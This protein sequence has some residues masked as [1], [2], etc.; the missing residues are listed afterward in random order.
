MPTISNKK[1]KFIEKNFKRC[2]I[3]E[4]SQKTGLKKHAI[5][6]LIDEFSASTVPTNQQNSKELFNNEAFWEV[7]GI[8]AIVLFLLTCSVYAPALKNGF[9]WDDS[10]YITENP[11]IRS[12]NIRSLYTMLTVR[13]VGNWHPLTSLSHALDYALWEFNPFGY[14]LTNIIFHSLNTIL[15]F[16]LV[17]LLMEKANTI[18]NM[19]PSSQTSLLP[20]TKALIAAGMTALLFALHPLQVESVVW[21]AERK[22]VLCTFF[23]L[24]TLVSYLMYISAVIP[25]AR[26]LWFMS[27]LLLFLFA[28]MSKPM[29]VTLPSVLLILDGYPLKRLSPS[30]RKNISVLLEKIPFFVLSIVDSTITILMQRN[31]GSLKSLEQ[32]NLGDRFFNA[33]ST[34]IFYLKKT[35]SPADLVPFYPLSSTV[36]RSV[37]VHLLTGIVVLAITGYCL[38]MAQKRKY[39]FLTA[40]LYYLV[41]LLPMIGIIQVGD[42]AAADRYTYL[43]NVSIFFLVG[44]ATVWVFEKFSLTNHFKLLRGL[45]VSLLLGGFILL[46]NLTVNQIKIWRNPESLWRYVTTHYPDSVP[47]SHYNLGIALFQEGKIDAAIAAYNHTITI[48][49]RY[50]K[51]Y[52]SLGYAYVKKGMLDKAIYDF[53]Q[54]I[55][56]NPRHAEAHYAL[57]FVF[58]EKGM[59]D[60]ALFEFKRAL[61]LKPRYAEVHYNLGVLY[62]KREKLDE[63]IS[64][65]KQAIANKPRYPE[66]HHDLAFAYYYTQKHQLA[67]IHC[68]KAMQLGYS[69]NP[70]LLELLKPYR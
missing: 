69:V 67:I 5:Q 31:A 33:L 65:F 70:Q 28:L 35:L 21:I 19:P 43:A 32:F 42:Q 10:A 39:L 47:L 22:N 41:M 54:A 29:A 48:A 17:I 11:M 23:A 37:G 66:A 25:R 58:N 49:P 7:A 30:F 27:S 38:W 59:S 6:S 18:N 63:A 12:L 16:L 51:A 3:E 61:T 36:D 62:Q 60:E 46:G 44:I 1:R 13:S 68:D 45:L 53:K 9:V 64:E 50:E 20:S 8:I 15:V 55:A 14:H 24:L 4:L 34:L 52:F 2:S 40:W 26:W 56:I 57:G